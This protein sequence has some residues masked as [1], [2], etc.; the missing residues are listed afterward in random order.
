M[1]TQKLQEF[2]ADLK[3]LL[4]N[5]GVNLQIEQK[6]V[7]VPNKPMEENTPEVTGT[8]VVEETAEVT[9]TETPTEEVA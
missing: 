5:Y 8:E 3:I 2:N 6:I 7:V 9:G 1:D 4:D